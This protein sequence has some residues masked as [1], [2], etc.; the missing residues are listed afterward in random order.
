M[1]SKVPVVWP[2]EDHTKVK[3][4]ILREY[5]RAWFRIMGFN[6]ERLLFID[7]YSGP[8]IY[9][10]GE[11]GSPIIVIK[12]AMNY[13]QECRSKGWKKPQIICLFI[14]EDV[15]RFGVLREQI[16]SMRIP[17][18][19]DIVL[20]NSS[21]ES[22]ATDI[23][24]FVESNGTTMVPTFAFIDPFGYNLPF[25]LIERMMKNPKTEV[26]INFMYE[27]L[28]RFFER[29]HQENAKTRLFGTTEWSALDLSCGPAERKRK[30]HDFYHLQLQSRAARYVRSFEM[31]GFRDTTKYFLF[32]GTNH[33][34]GLQKMKEAMW[35]VDQSGGFSFSDAT[36]PNQMVL[37]G[38]E[39]DFAYLRRL[40]TRRFA[41]KE[42]SIEEVENYVLTETPFLTTHIK[43]QVLKPMEQVDEIVVY[44]KRRA[45]T[46][47]P[48]TRMKFVES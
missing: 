37:F 31:R 20:E 42:A 30:I 12:E 6:E 23:L 29:E 21:F 7:G 2:L 5:L 3:H 24:D 40:I 41:G 16:N 33:K 19:I 15:E 28:N 36:D 8:G 48:R 25:E 39:P 10:Q 47:P 1:P 34:L 9:S 46:F 27:F 35:K 32:Y 13:L 26:F 22:I 14:E 11:D 44:G 43:R 18:S 38:N 45:G 4:I 17:R